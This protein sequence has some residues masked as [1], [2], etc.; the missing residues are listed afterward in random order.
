MGFFGRGRGKSDESASSKARRGVVAR[1]PRADLEDMRDDCIALFL[2]SGMTMK[3]VEGQGGPTVGTISKWLYKE[4]RFPRMDTIRA[5]LR[6][7]GADIVI[8]PAAQ[9]EQ[10]RQGRHY[11]AG[12]GKMPKR[13]SNKAKELR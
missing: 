12:P 9:A 6:A 1:E 13:G 7:V 11:P 10:I 2:N 4:T 5:F 8:V 3:Q